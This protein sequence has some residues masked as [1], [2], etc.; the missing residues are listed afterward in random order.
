MESTKIKESNNF[1]NIIKGVF[2]AFVTTLILLILYAIILTY[3]NVSEQ[4]ISPVVIVITG[5]SI[6]IGSTIGNHKIQKNGLLN[7]ACVGLIYIITIYLISSILSG[8][9]GLNVASIIMIAVSII[10]GILGGI[11]AVNQKKWI[12]KSKNKSRK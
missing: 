10:F 3:T 2:I 7:G 11:I 1:I 6:L 12:L 5:I 4:T 8:N 9:F